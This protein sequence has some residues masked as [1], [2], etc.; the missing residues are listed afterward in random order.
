MVEGRVS[1]RREKH[2][3]D[4]QSQTR[5]SGLYSEEAADH[6]CLEKNIAA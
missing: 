6:L 5:V 4:N 3:S 2:V 1:Q